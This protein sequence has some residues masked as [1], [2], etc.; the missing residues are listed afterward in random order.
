MKT[1]AIFTMLVLFWVLCSF[2]PLSE[3][4]L[5]FDQ[6][7]K[8]GKISIEAIGNEKS[9]HYYKPIRCTIINNTQNNLRFKIDVGSEFD[10]SPKDVQNMIVTDDVIV[11]LQRHATTTLN[12]P[13]FCTEHSDRAP[14]E[15]S[16]YAYQGITENDNLK[17][18]LDYVATKNGFNI[19]NQTVCWDLTED[20]NFYGEIVE[21]KDND[22]IPSFVSS[23]DGKEQDILPAYAQVNTNNSNGATY[24]G[25]F[26]VKYGYYSVVHIGIFNANNVV[27]KEILPEQQIKGDK[28]IPYSFAAADFE[29]GKYYIKLISNGETMLK[30]EVVI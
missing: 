7:L 27:V 28:E 25:K 6:L 20:P 15:E 4:I 12:L 18:F 14:N 2:A 21:V 23:K 3:N 1:K 19:G 8:E 13:A 16:K 26:T 22:G 24:H 5:S 29:P 11:S 17:K 30:Q 10:A 9:T